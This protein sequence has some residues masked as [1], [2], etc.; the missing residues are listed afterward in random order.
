VVILQAKGLVFAYDGGDDVVAGVDFTVGKSEVICVLGPNGAGK[1]TLLRLLGGLL[2]PRTGSVTLGDRPIAR[3]SARSRAKEIALVPQALFSLPDLSVRDFVSQGR[4][5]Y[6]TLFRPETEADRVAVQRALDE[7]DL[8]ELGNRALDSLSGG[9]RQRALVARAL[10]QEPRLVL[11]DE[12]TNS[13][14]PRHQ[15]QVFRVIAGL[16]CA[17]RAAVIVT[18]D[19]NLASQF[20]SRVVLMDEGRVVA[21]GSVHDVLRPEVLHPVY[22]EHLAF[23]SRFVSGWGE[24]RPYVLSWQKPDGG[25]LE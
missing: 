2:P 4:Y 5:A 8:E 17:G 25:P 13:L 19:L 16:G 6:R 10:A 20:A 18:H 21:S 23:G 24:E 14:D 11:V 9:Q 22:G 3:Y 1:S 15:V 7:A 12:P